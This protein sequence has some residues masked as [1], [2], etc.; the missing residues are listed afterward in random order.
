VA[1]SISAAFM[2]KPPSPVAATTLASTARSAARPPGTAMP[3]EA[4]P[5]EMMQVFGS[6]VGKV[7]RGR[8]PG[9]AH[10]REE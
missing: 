6:S 8:H 9:A 5:L 1:V 4:R 7:L 10:V 3:I 2:R